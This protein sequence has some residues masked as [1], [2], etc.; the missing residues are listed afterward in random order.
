MI[1]R[2]P[3]III[4]LPV[5]PSTNR[6]QRS[7]I[8]PN[9]KTGKLHAV[10]ISTDDYKAWQETA[11]IYIAQQTHGNFVPWRY[12]MRIT[13]GEG[14]VDPSNRI[15]AVEDILQT[16]GVIANDKHLRMLE[17]IVDEDQSPMNVKVEIWSHGPQPTKG[18]KR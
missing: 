18:K 17:L 15:K 1:D 6:L 12:E 3:D 2:T 11:A 7:A 5:P 4:T 16:C 14:R 8:R 9:K 10:R 13:I